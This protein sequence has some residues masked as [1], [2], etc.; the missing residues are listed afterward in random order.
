VELAGRRGRLDARA[1]N[2]GAECERGASRDRGPDYNA[3]SD[4][5]TDG[6]RPCSREYSIL[7]ERPLCAEYPLYA[8]RPLHAKHP[9]SFELAF[10]IDL[11]PQNGERHNLPVGRRRLERHVLQLGLR[12]GS[13]AILA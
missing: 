13:G 7:A 10:P 3:G 11:H 5:F 6:E 1:S 8:E 12:W 2:G 4:R 9:R